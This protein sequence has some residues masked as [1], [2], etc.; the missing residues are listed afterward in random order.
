MTTVF[1]GGSRTISQLS[2]LVRRRLDTIA[3]KQIPVLVGDANG[4]DKAVQ[5][6]LRDIHYEGVTVFCTG[7]VC[8]NN[9]GDWPVTQVEPSGIGI[10]KDRK[11]FALKDRAMSGKATHGFML[12]DGESLG[13]LVNVVRLRREGRTS[14]VYLRPTNS[15]IDVRNDDDCKNL[16]KYCSSELLSKAE[17]EVDAELGK[18]A[19]RSESGSLT[20]F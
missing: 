19:R 12:W 16:V 4:A 11:F 15:F 7:T 17:L 9:L 18:G 14:V 8:R 6:Y 10:R 1:I 2:D 5:A 13:T 3:D 20:L